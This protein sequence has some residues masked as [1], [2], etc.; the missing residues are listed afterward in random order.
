M[1]NVHFDLTDIIKLTDLKDQVEQA[2]KNAIRD[3]SAMSYGHLVEQVQNK[4]HST[5]EK[6]LEALS[7]SQIDEQTWLINLDSKMV[8]LEDGMPQHEMIDDLLKSSKAKTSKS[9]SKYLAIPFQHNVKPT[10]ST[11]AQKSLTETIKAELSKRNIP[12]G[13]LEKDAQGNVKKGLL[14]KIDITNN[15]IKT[16]HAP[17]Q[18]KGPIGSPFQGQTGIPFLK[19]IRIYQKDVKDKAGKTTTAKGIMTFRTVSSTQKGS[20]KWVYPEKEGKFFLDETASWALEQWDKK[21]KDQIIAN[22]E[23]S[24]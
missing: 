12:Y 23:K 8:W 4:L 16:A 7:I 2:A 15:P 19:G 17:G 18:G 24:F 14:H 22:I 20:G 21:I 6:Y 3:L 5:R 1:I 13:D 11:S 9:G 10:A